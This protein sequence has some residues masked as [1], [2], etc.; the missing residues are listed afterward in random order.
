MH[1]SPE[2]SQETTG[3]GFTDSREVE[4]AAGRRPRWG[5]PGPLAALALLAAAI[6]IAVVLLQ[7]RPPREITIVDVVPGAEPEIAAVAHEATEVA[8]ALVRRFPDQFDSWHVLALFYYE[9]GKL[10]EAVKCWKRCLELDPQFPQGYYRV[11]VVARD[12]GKNEEAVEWFRKALK[13]APGEP[14]VSVHLAQA[15]IDLG[16]TEEAIEVL[17]ANLAAYPCSL[18]SF[19]LLGDVYVQL[20]QCD[21]AKKHLETAIEMSPDYTCAYYSLAMAC[22]GLGETAESKRYMEKF[23][24]LKARDEQAHR[25]WLRTGDDLPR[26]QK[27]ASEILTAA[28]KAYLAQGDPQTAETLLLR[29]V[30]LCESEPECHQVLAWLYEQQGRTDEARDALSRGC[31]AN[32]EDLGI[33]LRLGALLA[34]QGK[35]D[36]AEESLEKAIQIMPYQGGGYAAL[37]NMHLMSGRKLSDAKKLA[38]KAVE[39]EPLAKNYFLLGSI[40]QRVGDLAAA[41]AA[42]EQAV[43]L[44][45]GNPQYR[46][47]YELVRGGK[48]E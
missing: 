12:R 11:G 37:A 19:V 14:Q 13:H 25:D 8:E 45:P 20:K 32:P 5:L 36:T 34:G 26:V 17:E 24:E 15:L 6:A 39:L 33:H 2:I 28:G 22:G 46:Q 3:G 41:R 16:E 27:D 30:E 1:E 44:E 9:F 7:V 43:A 23:K 31:K 48:A 29:A 21:K 4:R 10:D 35:F 18:P 47:A 38:T 42:I 40:C